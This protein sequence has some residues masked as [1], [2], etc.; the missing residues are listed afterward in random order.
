MSITEQEWLLMNVEMKLRRLMI[1][2]K[3]A[4]KASLFRRL[5]VGVT[6][7]Q[8]DSILEKLNADGLCK[9]VSGQKG[10]VRYILNENSVYAGR[11]IPIEPG[12]QQ[13]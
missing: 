13:E 4:W 9:S 3:V 5:G 10:G 11:S 1:R 6:A 12:E 2:E 8:F 7:E